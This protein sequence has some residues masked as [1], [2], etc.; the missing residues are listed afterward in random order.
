MLLTMRPTGGHS[1]A[2]ADRQDWTVLDEGRPVGRIYEDM[3]ASASTD[4]RW[5]W[6]ITVYVWPDAGIATSGKAATLDQ[7]K[8][9]FQRGSARWGEAGL[10]L[11]RI[12]AA[13]M[14]GFCHPVAR[15]LKKLF[16]NL[17][18]SRKSSKPHALA[19]VPI[20]RSVRSGSDRH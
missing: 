13:L 11:N 19:S 8:A 16:P 1:P 10:E 20:R 9:E 5:T 4:Q 3:S 12:L 15:H 18:I 2:Y 7:A 14:H 6:S 17:L